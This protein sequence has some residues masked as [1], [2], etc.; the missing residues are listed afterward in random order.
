M[1]D[2]LDHLLDQRSRASYKS[3]DLREHD[4][5]AATDLLTRACSAVGLDREQLANTRKTDP[6]KQ[7][8]AWLLRRE[9]TA[10]N[11]WISD[12]LYM[13]HEVNISQSVRRVCEG[14]TKDVQRYK[15]MLLKTLKSKD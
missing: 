2:R 10:R 5:R 1:L 9:T 6:R 15:A 3:S 14:A 4:E 12:R 13:G 11:R 8:V 7:V